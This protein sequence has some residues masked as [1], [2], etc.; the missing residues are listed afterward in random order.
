VAVEEEEEVAVEGVEAA[1]AA[2]AEAEPLAGEERVMRT[3]V[4]ESVSGSVC[5]V[6]E[7][8]RPGRYRRTGVY[9]SKAQATHQKR[10]PS[11]E[12]RTP[13]DHRSAPTHPEKHTN[14]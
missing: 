6:V 8:D 9:V 2:G 4:S 7:F 10:T 12:R 14:T 13:T 3:V 11:R 1:A 5:T